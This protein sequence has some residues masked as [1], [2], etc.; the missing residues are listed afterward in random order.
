VIEDL[1]A[2]GGVALLSTLSESLR[3]EAVGQL[4]VLEQ[5]MSANDAVAATAAAHRIKGAAW[6]LGLRGL[7][8]ACLGLEHALAVGMADT[9]RLHQ[10]VVKAYE[11]GQNALDTIVKGQS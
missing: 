1:L 6:S 4:P 3:L 10:E 11:R 9:A 2:Q 7:A 8:S 5:A